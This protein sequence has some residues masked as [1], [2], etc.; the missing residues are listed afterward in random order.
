[1]KISAIVQARMGSIR[2][3]KKVMKKIVNEPM[4]G[5]LLKR[6]SKSKLLNQIILA[7]SIDPI[8]EPLVN[9][10]ESL[11]FQCERGSPDDVLDRYYQIALKSKADAIVRITGDCP[12]VDA[13]LVDECIGKFNS[14][15]VDYFSNT[16]PP[17]FPDGLDIE[18]IKFSA[19]EKAVNK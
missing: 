5:L 7:T 3:S 4:I 11:G 15:N 14:L 6:L 8:E 19:L 10:V 18:V 12:L 1:M 9:Y 2:L 13:E 17:T 16:I